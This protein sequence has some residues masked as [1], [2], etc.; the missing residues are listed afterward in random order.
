MRQWLARY[1]LSLLLSGGIPEIIIDGVSGMLC[2]SRNP[3]SLAN[4]IIFLLDNPK[5]RRQICK[6]AYEQFLRKYTLEKMIKNY[7]TAYNI[8]INKF[9]SRPQ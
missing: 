7:E 8:T 5:V 4:A 1:Q 9:H 6:T 3:K 2:G